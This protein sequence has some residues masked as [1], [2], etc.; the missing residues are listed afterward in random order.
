M[1]LGW[2]DGTRD[3]SEAPEGESCVWGGCYVV[4][5][6]QIFLSQS[7]VGGGGRKVWGGLI[8]CM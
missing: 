4:G 5:P 1:I 8:Y 2:G 6:F 7:L 3:S